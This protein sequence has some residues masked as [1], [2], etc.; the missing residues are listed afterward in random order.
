M[1]PANFWPLVR[2]AVRALFERDASLGGGLRFVEDALDV[3]LDAYIALQGDGTQV[4]PAN[5]VDHP[6]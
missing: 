3:G 5:L 6:P 4:G 2:D 1:P